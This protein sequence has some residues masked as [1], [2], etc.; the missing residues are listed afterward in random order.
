MS[1][2]ARFLRTR[3]LGPER[4]TQTP[5]RKGARMRLVYPRNPHPL[6]PGG[7]LSGPALLPPLIPTLRGDANLEERQGW[8]A[9]LD[10]ASGPDS[11]LAA[12]SISRATVLSSLKRRMAVSA[13]RAPLSDGRVGATCLET[14]SQSGSL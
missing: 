13:L 9:V 5:E 14:R 11:A 1:G 7:G 10:L 12:H 8:L 2:R 3:G 4:R 6:A